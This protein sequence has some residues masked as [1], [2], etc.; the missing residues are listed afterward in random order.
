AADL[1]HGVRGVVVAVPV[2]L[3]RVE[4]VLEV[5][6]R[7]RDLAG[8]VL[9][10]QLQDADAG[11]GARETGPRPGHVREPADVIVVAAL[12]L[13]DGVLHRLVLDVQPGV[14]RRAQRNY[15]HDRHGDVRTGRSRRV[16]PAALAI[17]RGDDEIHR[18]LEDRL[19]RLVACQAIDLAQH[20]RRHAVAVHV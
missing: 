12:D 1:V 13:G 2:V 8:L 14:L 10:G 9:T 6:D 17:L 18:L 19:D 5:L 4:V 15:L 7:P 20:Q 3:A 16:A 11:G